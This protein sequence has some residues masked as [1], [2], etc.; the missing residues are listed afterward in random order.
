MASL[1]QFLTGKRNRQSS[2]HSEGSNSSSI[3][4][5]KKKVNANDSKD[6]N[7]SFL[8]F[9]DNIDENMDYIKDQFEGDDSMPT[10]A[11]YMYR[12]LCSIDNKQDESQAKMDNTHDEN[13][14]KMNFIIAGMDMI[15]HKLEG[16]I[17][18]SKESSKKVTALTAQVDLL[19]R[20]N[21]VLKQKLTELEDYSKKYN[22]K[23][24]N[25][26]E[27]PR[28]DSHELMNKLADIMAGMD[29]NI[30]DFYIDNIHRLP[31]YGKG[32][33]PVILKFVSALDKNLFWSRCN[34]LR[35]TNL[36]FR[37][38]FSKTTED[39]IKVLLPIRRA[40]IENKLNVKM[41]ADKLY[42]NN[43]KYVAKSLDKLPNVLQH[44]R[45]GCKVLEDRLFFFSHVSPLSNFHPSPFMVDGVRFSCGEQYVQWRKASVQ[46]H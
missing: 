1:K 13:Q 19:H 31:S 14:E 27:S 29:L 26:E 30:K 12:K 41:S 45:Y 18:E 23:I 28:E 33:R 34:R 46:V 37:E 5:P 11:K 16:I 22:I 40:D 20:E 6:S 8:H 39:N 44:A 43:T 36:Q 2:S 9:L 15:E 7:D 17:V 25:L 24:L 4:P 10:W 38:H 35:H 21:Q 32:P 3:S 42:I